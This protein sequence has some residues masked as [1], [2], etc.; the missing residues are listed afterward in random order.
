MAYAAHRRHEALTNQPPSALASTL[1]L[2]NT[3]VDVINRGYSGYT[4]RW[5]RALLA[6]LFSTT[7]ERR[8]DNFPRET[9]PLL[10]TI[11]LGAN[12]AAMAGRARCAALLIST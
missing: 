2:E 7:E 4:S 1:T 6:S 3:Q 9:P 5:V 8:V 10:V 12:D 11:W